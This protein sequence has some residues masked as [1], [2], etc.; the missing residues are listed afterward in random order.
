MFFC[1]CNWDAR[2]ALVAFDWTSHDNPHPDDQYIWSCTDCHV[3]GCELH[4]ISSVSNNDKSFDLHEIFKVLPSVRVEKEMQITTIIPDVISD[5]IG[6]WSI[7]DDILNKVLI[8]LKPG[9]LIRAAATCHHLRTL[10]AS[11]MPCMKLKLFPHQEAAVEWMLRREQN[12]EPLAH[13]LCKNFCT[14]DGFP[15]F[16]NVTSGEIFTGIAPTI[17]DFCG[18][19][20][21]DEPGLGKTVTALSLILKTHGTLTE[22]PR[23][24]DIKWCT[25]KPDKKYG[26][27]EFNTSNCSNSL[28][29]SKRLMGKNV[30]K[31]DRS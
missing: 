10:A 15:F 22:P 9:D 4:Q 20:F 11:I 13:P 21:C 5:E 27:Y 31:E 3:L 12:P 25:H 7:P 6:I 16:I 23:G 19:M 26:Y 8:R 24:V 30:V 29:E 28:S 2:N 1:S 14:E 18:G 17:N